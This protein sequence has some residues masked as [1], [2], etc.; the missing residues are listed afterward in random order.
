MITHTE[1]L[2]LLA[3][4]LLFGGTGLPNYR[5][6]LYSIASFCVIVLLL[7]FLLNHL[8]HKI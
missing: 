6:V 3:V 5:S 4:I 7:E 1:F 8:G 2:I